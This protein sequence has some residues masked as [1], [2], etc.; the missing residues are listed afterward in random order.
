MNLYIEKYSE[1][2]KKSWDDFVMDNSINGTFL[3]T[4]RFLSYHPVNKFEDVSILIF[5]NNKIVAVCPACCKKENGK[6]FFISHSGST[7]GG[8]ILSREYYKADKVLQLIDCFENY[9]LTEGYVEIKLKIT[10]DIFS[11]S[12]SSLLQ[13][14]L[15]NKGYQS[16]QELNR[17]EER[18]VGKECL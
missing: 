11:R 16:Y 7:Y 9:V 14:C 10:P 8:L 1:V 4:R 13:Y 2:Y 17:S 18:R 5:E 15:Y 3:Q 6:K 12:G